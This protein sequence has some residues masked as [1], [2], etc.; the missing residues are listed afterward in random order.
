MKY[1]CDF[2][3]QKKRNGAAAFQHFHK[4]LSVPRGSAPGA[5]SKGA[6]AKQAQYRDLWDA[7]KVIGGEDKRLGLPLREL[8]DYYRESV[9][10]YDGGPTRNWGELH[11]TGHKA[12]VAALKNQFSVHSGD[13]TLGVGVGEGDGGLIVSEV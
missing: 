13:G 1:L 7:L 9:D 8:E 3:L 2:I 11:S 4:L 10:G 6:A 12:K 5:L